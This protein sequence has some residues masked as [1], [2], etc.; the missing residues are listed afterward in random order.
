MEIEVSA[1]HQDTGEF[2][3]RLDDFWEDPIVPHQN[4]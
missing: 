4:S 3:Q 1:V 2:G